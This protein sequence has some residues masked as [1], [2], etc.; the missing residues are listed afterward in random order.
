MK[1]QGWKTVIVLAVV[2]AGVVFVAQVLRGRRPYTVHRSELSGWHVVTGRT[3]GGV[4]V[5][6]R[7][8]PALANDLYDQVTRRTSAELSAPEQPIVPLVLRDEFDISLM[9]VLSAQDIVD[10]ARESGIE[11]ASFEPVCMAE[12]SD[13]S[14]AETERLFFVLFQAPEFERARADLMLMHP[15]HGGAVEFDPA[16]LSPILTVAA[17]DD[18]FARWWSLLPHDQTDCQIAMRTE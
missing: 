11:E 9:G 15:E 2:V 16:A 7:P 13:A 10:I 1:G 6:L 3:G 12:H 18:R 17:T 8:P 14:G 5:G 4:A